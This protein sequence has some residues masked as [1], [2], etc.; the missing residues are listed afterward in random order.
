MSD[1]MLTLARALRFAAEAHRDQ[2][3]KGAAQEPYVNHLIEVMDLAARATGGRDVELM[4]AALCHDVVEDTAVT[5]EELASGFGDRV[6]RIV[7]ENSDDMSLPKPERRAA[8]IAAMAHKAPDARIV[9]TADVISNLRAVVTSAPAG[10]G[11]ERK[12]GYLEGCRALIEAGRVETADLEALFDET[13]AEAE[14]AIRGD[15]PMAVEGRAEAVRHLESGIG[16]PVHLVYLANTA[17]RPITGGDIARLATIAGETF[18]SVTVQEAQAYFDGALRPILVARIRSED[19]DAIVAL[20]QRLC[21]AFDERF[22][23]IEVQG[24]Y[25]R[26]YADDT[27]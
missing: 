21:L 19:S 22:V 1:D 7:A 25:I 13:A 5:A 9:K 12:L 4:I 2:R 27:G 6:A 20:A 23:G 8:R 17:Q 14:A 10:W 16:Q 11:P 15:R 24:R 26:V 18:P 3:R